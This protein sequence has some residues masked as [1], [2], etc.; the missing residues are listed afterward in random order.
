MILAA[1]AI[2][3]GLYLFSNYNQQ[4]LDLQ[5]AIKK[6]SD[7]TAA[8]ASLQADMANLKEEFATQKTSLAA[9]K[10][11]VHQAANDIL[12]IKTDTAN[13][14]ADIESIKNSIKDWQKDFITALL[15]IEKKSDDAN[16]AV[17]SLNDQTQN[18]KAQLSIQ[19]IPGLQEEV[20]SLKYHLNQLISTLPA[21][22]PLKQSLQNQQHPSVFKK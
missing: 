9:Q 8:I 17:K 16:D 5:T 7:Q 22:D 10:E 4:N 3:L 18:L 15:N 21:S 14:R 19:N 11:Q 1:S 20:K 2:A 6:L 13:T 12:K